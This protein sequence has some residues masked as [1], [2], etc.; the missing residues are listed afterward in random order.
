MPVDDMPDMTGVETEAVEPLGR[1]R[2][3][4]W[5]ARAQPSRAMGGAGLEP[6]ATCV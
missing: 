1:P 6:A 3:E 2:E 5:D 4:N